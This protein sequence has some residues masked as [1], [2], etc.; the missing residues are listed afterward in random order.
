MALGAALA[1]ER[2]LA[3]LVPR[4]LVATSPDRRGRGRLRRAW[5]RRVQGQQCLLLQTLRVPLCCG[6]CP[7]SA[8]VW[9]E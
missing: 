4:S 1:L 5:A 8:E 9:P 6:R 3:A 7:H 2:G